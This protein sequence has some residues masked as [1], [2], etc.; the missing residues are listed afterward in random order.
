M[1]RCLRARIAALQSTATTGRGFILIRRL[2]LPSLVLLAAIPIVIGTAAGAN[3]RS[4]AAHLSQID[5]IVVIYEEN[6]SFD[7][8][9]GGW[10]GVNGLASADAAHTTQVNQSGTAFSCLQQDDVNLT[11]PPLA[12]T[13]TDSTVTPSFTSAFTNAPFQID[14]FIHPQDVT[15]PKPTVFGPPAGYLKGDPHA[16]LGGCTRDLVH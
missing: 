9:F 16:L 12:A 3:P 4:D 11:S 14:A 8:L 6:H 10:E 7:N 1:T 15:C 2:L 13:C 5:H